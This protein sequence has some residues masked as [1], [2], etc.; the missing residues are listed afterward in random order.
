MQGI[1]K[2]FQEAYNELKLSTWL[3]RKEMM[4]STVIVVILTVL[5]ALYVAGVDRVLLAI[6]NLLFR[7]G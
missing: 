1:V 4:G 3:S 2:F 7:I 6:V 5:V